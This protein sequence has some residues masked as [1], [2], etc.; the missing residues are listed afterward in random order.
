VTNV[1]TDEADEARGNK[2]RPYDEDEDEERPSR[3]TTT[4]TTPTPTPTPPRSALERRHGLVLERGS[5][6]VP[7]RSGGH[8]HTD[9][10]TGIDSAQ[11]SVR[12]TY[13]GK[14]SALSFPSRLEV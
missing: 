14:G 2:I 7:T 6:R 10:Q 3:T 4:T 12:G 13:A 1:P 8:R 5:Q 9:A 11:S